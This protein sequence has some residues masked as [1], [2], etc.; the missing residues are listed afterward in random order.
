MATL[1]QAARGIASVISQ[2]VSA[3]SASTVRVQPILRQ[4]AIC[5]R[6]EE[7]QRS[8]MN[9]TRPLAAAKVQKTVKK[10]ATSFKKKAPGQKGSE[11]SSSSVGKQNEQFY[12]AAPTVELSEFYPESVDTSSIGHVYQLSENFLSKLKQ[13]GY[14]KALDKE[15][16]LFHKPSL[17]V[18][19]CTIELISKINKAGG[20]NSAESRYI[21]TG[22]VGAGKS[23][24][25]LQAI[26][27]CHDKNW[28]VI[29]IPRAI[30][31]MDSSQPF[32]KSSTGNEYVQPTV[33]LSIL[34]QI[35][36]FNS[37]ILN[38]IQLTKDYRFAQHSVEKSLPLSKLLD[39]GIKDQQVS[40]PVFEAFLNEVSQSNDHSVLLAI[41]EINAFYTHSEY[42]DIESKPLEAYR[43]SFARTLLDYFSG[44]KSFAHG[45]CLGAVSNTLAPFK[46]EMLDIALGLV[47][48]DPYKRVNQAYL[49]LA[50]GIKPIAIPAYSREEALGVMA[51][52]SK[53]HIVHHEPTEDIFNQKFLAT[54]GN[55]RKFYT[56]CAMGV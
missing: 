27:Y 21:L 42:N 49:D 23:A 2:R 25:M 18:R 17:A 47:K 11:A 7:S 56:S 9:S 39:I 34:Q 29:Y 46:S 30:K 31:S 36:T 35:K 32:G 44:K 6:I 3:P 5:V 26:N 16:S 1:R 13:T 8:F 19:K 52:Y 15:F 28:I 54:S 53:A 24:L 33:A 22:E 12:K 20:N 43:L 37:E 10:K 48:I 45:V 55:P 38:K 40:Q 41:D 51:Y 50:Q 4:P 14:P